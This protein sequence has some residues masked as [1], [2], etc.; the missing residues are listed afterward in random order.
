MKYFRYILFLPFLTSC[1]VSINKQNNVSDIENAKKTST[2]FYQ[3]VKEKRFAE[4]AKYF[5]TTIGYEDGLKILGN[6]NE[7]IG[8]LDSVVFVNGNSNTTI[9]SKKDQAQFELNFKA[10]YQK[11]EANEE[12]V[13][14]LINDSLKITG[15]HPRVTIPP[16]N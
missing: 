3:L 14:E 12:M 1:E 16:S 2:V 5:G 15:Y 10:F 9:S 7:H 13:I 6:V 11:M 4:A 8:N